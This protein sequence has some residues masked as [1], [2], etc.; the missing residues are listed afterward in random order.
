MPDP[1]RGPQHHPRSCQNSSEEFGNFQRTISGFLRRYFG[2]L[3]KNQMI[4]RKNQT[5]SPKNFFVP[6]WKMKNIHGRNPQIAP[7]KS[8]SSRIKAIRVTIC[9]D[10]RSVRPLCQIR[11]IKV[12]RVTICRDARSCVRCVRGYSV[13]F[14]STCYCVV[15][16]TGTDARSCVRC[17]KG[18]RV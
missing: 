18:Y 3:R 1:L 17:V 6:P 11:C 13:K 15:V 16:L 8:K 5:I 9:R 14:V 12:R 2:F 7:K 4:L 10:A